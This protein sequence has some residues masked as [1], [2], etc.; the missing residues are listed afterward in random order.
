MLDAVLVW[1]RRDLRDADH[2]ALSEALR[3]RGG[4]LIVRHAVAASEIPRL[5][6]E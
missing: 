6:R 4:G 1:F 5:A 2:A 3:Q